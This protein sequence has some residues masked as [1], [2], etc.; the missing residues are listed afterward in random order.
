MSLLCFISFFGQPFCHISYIW[1]VG[2]KSLFSYIQLSLLER[3]SPLPSRESETSGALLLATA[4]NICPQHIQEREDVPLS[5]P[6]RRPRLLS[7]FDWPLRLWRT[8][9]VGHFSC[10][11][12]LS[13]VRV[14]PAPRPGPRQP[15]LLRQLLH[16]NHIQLFCLRQRGQ[17]NRG[18]VR[19][20]LLP[21]L[22]PGS[23]LAFPLQT[24]SMLHDAALT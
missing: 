12:L 8:D 7:L 11:F 9:S 3:P 15:R 1:T 14:V 24:C 17:P 4:R 20:W 18:Q 22:R 13:C 2:R 21:L 10:S 16:G 23:V 6:C 19:P 5:D